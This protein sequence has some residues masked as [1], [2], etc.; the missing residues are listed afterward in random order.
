[1]VG[2][3]DQKWGETPHA[4]VVLRPAAEAT[5][6]DLH[7]FCRQHLAHFKVPGKFSFVAELSKTATGKIQKFVLRN[8]QSAISR[9]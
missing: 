6:T 9:Q 8:K 3:P 5:A 7:E 1:M 4:F 2:V